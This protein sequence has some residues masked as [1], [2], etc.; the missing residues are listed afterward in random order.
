MKFLNYSSHKNTNNIAVRKTTLRVS[1]LEILSVLASRI[2]ISAKVFSSL[3][4]FKYTSYYITSLTIGYILY[5]F[6][7]TQNAEKVN[8]EEEEAKACLGFSCSADSPMFCLTT[9]FTFFTQLLFISDLLYNKTATLLPLWYLA[10]H[11]ILG[12]RN[13]SEK[14]IKFFFHSSPRWTPITC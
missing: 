4:Y 3:K 9:D 2:F 6:L 11:I 5:C 8:R 7:K 1:L 10:S 13:Y 14:N 12:N